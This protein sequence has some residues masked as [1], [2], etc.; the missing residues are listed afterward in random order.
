MSQPFLIPHTPEAGLTIAKMLLDI[1]AV[2]LRPEQPY[3][4]TS[5]WAAPTYIDCRRVI[6]FPHV[7][8]AI[9]KYFAEQ[10]AAIGLDKIDAV[11]GGETAGIPYSAWLAEALNKPMLY[12]RKKPKGFGR[13][14][15]IEGDFQNN[16]NVLLVEDLATDGASKVAFVNALRDGGCAVTDC[17]VVFYYGVFPSS[18][19]LEKTG[20]NL[21]YLC[22]WPDILR[23][24]TEGKYFPPTTVA[25]V[26]EF[27]HDPAGWSAA[28]GG[29]SSANAKLS[30]HS[31]S[32]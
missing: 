23:A 22:S 14:A 26:Q 9:T 18:G 7:R 15:Q 25:A 1:K 29:A 31:G 21:R 19:E 16:K 4:L 12:V 3:I 27:L 8:Q 24:A 6:S 10:C 20:I 11:A 2:N 28:H 32:K 30:S 5:G 17:L 13:G